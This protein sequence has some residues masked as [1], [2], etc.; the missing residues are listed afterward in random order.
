MLLTYVKLE[1]FIK[2]MRL[3]QEILNLEKKNIVR[4]NLTMK[5]YIDISLYTK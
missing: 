3:L 1:K 2:K 5:G 4:K